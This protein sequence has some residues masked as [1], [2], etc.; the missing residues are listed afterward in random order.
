MFEEWTDDEVQGGTISQFLQENVFHA[1]RKR[2]QV[3]CRKL[4]KLLSE[5]LI[6]RVSL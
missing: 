4:R 1:Q 2:V 6:V 5:R 3:L